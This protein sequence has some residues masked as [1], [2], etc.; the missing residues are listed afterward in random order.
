MKCINDKS[1]THFTKYSSHKL[2]TVLYSHNLKNTIV[3]WVGGKNIG[4]ELV[5]WELS[6]DEPQITWCQSGLKIGTDLLDR[7]QK[8]KTENPVRSHGGGV[9][10]KRE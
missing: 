2:I 4:M 9:P 10:E 5:E 3:G 7:I 1:S 8:I 6:I